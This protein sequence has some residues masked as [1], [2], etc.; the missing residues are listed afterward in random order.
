M[1]PTLQQNEHRSER[2]EQR[3]VETEAKTSTPATR[4]E[5]IYVRNFDI[6]RTYHLTVEVRD[7]KGLVFGNRY[8]LTPGKTV[9]ELG[10]LPPGEYEI[11]VELDGRRRQ[12]VRCEVDGTL[13]KTA[14]I[15]V[16]NGTVS[17]TEGLYS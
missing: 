12:T 5:E 15:E 3:A 13:D 8:R 10:Q 17:V 4:S 16:G 14:L 6:S 1:A 11:H 7:S 2:T 9:S